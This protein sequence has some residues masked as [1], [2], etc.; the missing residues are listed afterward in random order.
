MGKYGIPA[1]KPI[2]I[3]ALREEGDAVDVAHGLEHLQISIHA[4][5][6]EG[7]MS[8]RG[9]GSASTNF[10]PRP[11]RGGRRQP[12][13]EVLCIHSISIHALREEGDGFLLPFVFHSSAISIHALREEGDRHQI[14]IYKN[15]L[16][17]YPRPPRGGRRI[18]FGAFR[19]ILY[20][21]PRPPRGGRPVQ[22]Q[23][24]GVRQ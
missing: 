14:V 17:F 4:L 19:R 10:Y 22:A 3:H 24:L 16:Y 21:Y 8:K 15:Y 12:S 5:R 13:Q 2:S 7:D 6:E 18:V 9:S 23:A 1:I 11:P 20:F